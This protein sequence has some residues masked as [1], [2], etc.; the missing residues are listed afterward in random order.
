MRMAVATPPMLPLPTVA[1]SAVVSAWKGVMVFAVASRF[2]VAPP[3][4]ILTAAGKRRICTTPVISVSSPPTMTS[5]S[6]IANGCQTKLSSARICSV[7][8]SRFMGSFSY[9]GPV[10]GISS[11]PSR[12]T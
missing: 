12:G 8:V 4:T 3:S 1:A 7:R 6:G 11:R 2:A 5:T 9:R 10:A